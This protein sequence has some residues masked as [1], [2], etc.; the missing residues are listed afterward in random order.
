MK[1][2]KPFPIRIRPNF[3]RSLQCT[4]VLFLC[5]QFINPAVVA[6]AKPPVPFDP[7]I[8]P[9]TSWNTDSGASQSDPNSLQRVIV[10]LAG[11]PSASYAAAGKPIRMSDAQNFK[12]Q[13]A[14]QQANFLKAMHSKGISASVN[15]QFSG[16]LFNG[17]AM[18][19]HAGDISKL[20]QVSQ[21]TAVY[22]DEQ[23]H[24]DL[25]QSVPLIGAP[26][27]WDL[28]DSNNQPVDGRGMRVAI[29]D[30]GVD[31]N[32]PDLGGGFGPGYKVE[33][34]Y[35]YVNYDADQK[36]IPYFLGAIPLGNFL[37]H[38]KETTLGIGVGI[39]YH[40]K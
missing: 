25:N 3:Q 9:R 37:E 8:P 39:N 19:V 2:L 31:Y 21:V 7:S 10:Q 32:H 20:R 16:E 1:P 35:D 33:G 26:A 22:P 14:S 36:S 13:I 40:I 38:Y 5:L 12:A 15:R 28:S 4:L 27:V 30:S 6:Q 24:A 11:K 23:M 34:G 29:I 18:T 17:V